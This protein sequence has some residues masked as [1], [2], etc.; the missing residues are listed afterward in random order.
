[1]ATISENVEEILNDFGFS[2]AECKLVDETK[3]ATTSVGLARVTTISQLVLAKS[4][5]N[6]AEKVIA[7]NERL[8]GSNEKYSKRM[9]RLTF[10]LVFVGFLQ[11]YTAVIQTFIG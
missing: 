4:I 8:S 7:S 6:A 2:P 5:R 10:A 3:S 1:M 9:V 11:A